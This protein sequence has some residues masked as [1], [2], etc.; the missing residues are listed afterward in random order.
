MSNA[1]QFF[2]W[3]PDYDIGIQPIDDQ[4]RVLVNTLNRLSMAVA[5]HDGEK[6][7][8]G[9]FDAL[10][11]YTRTHFNLE[12]RLMRQAKYADIDAHIEEHQR[13][14][15]QLEQL[16]NR[17]FREAEPVYTELLEFMKVWLREHIQGVDTKYSAD[18]RQSGFSLSNWERDATAEFA[19]VESA[20]KQWWEVWR[21]N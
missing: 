1:Q 7:I 19:L 10:M 11:S 5:R 20:K 16:F 12:E 21:A 4:H 9:I 6:V 2:P 17:H 18:L 8:A 15:G 14:I 13:L 3:S